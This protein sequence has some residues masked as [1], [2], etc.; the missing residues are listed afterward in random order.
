MR[1]EVGGCEK[2]RRREGARMEEGRGQVE[3]QRRQ[4]RKGEDEEDVW[5]GRERGYTIVVKQ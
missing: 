4:R 3:R 1:E 5:R 2:G